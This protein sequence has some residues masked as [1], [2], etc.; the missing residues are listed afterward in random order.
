MKNA[1]R[2]LSSASYLTLC[3]LSLLLVLPQERYEARE[4]TTLPRELLHVLD[5]GIK[6]FWRISDGWS[7]N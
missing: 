6:A 4:A 2:P 5:F 1:N 3:E 7:I